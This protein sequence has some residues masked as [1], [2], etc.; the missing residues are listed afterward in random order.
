[1]SRELEIYT[2]SAVKTRAG[3]S[4]CCL[5]YFCPQNTI[6]YYNRGSD[7]KSSGREKRSEYC[8]IYPKKEKADYDFGCIIYKTVVQ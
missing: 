4:K 1:M 8:A 2:K 6:S 7:P 3:R 5:P